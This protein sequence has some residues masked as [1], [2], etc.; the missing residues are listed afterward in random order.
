VLGEMARAAGFQSVRL[1][2][3]LDGRPYDLMGS[4]DLVL[5]AERG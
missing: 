5:L 4:P 1:C 2:G 3:H